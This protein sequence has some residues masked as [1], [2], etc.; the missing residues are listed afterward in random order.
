M[1]SVTNKP[2]MMSAITLNVAFSYQ[3][4][5]YRYAEWRYAECRGALQRSIH[6]YIPST[7][8]NV[9]NIIKLFFVLFHS[10]SHY[11]RIQYQINTQNTNLLTK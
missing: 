4:A 3:Y 5:E 8:Y 6:L 9:A 2:S 7:I 11:A 10:Y 1:L